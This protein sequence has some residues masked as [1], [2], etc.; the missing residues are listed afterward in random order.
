LTKLQALG[1]SFGLHFA[2]LLLLIFGNLD[3]FEKPVPQ[4][5]IRVNLGKLGIKRDQSLL[6]RIDA[7][8]APSPAYAKASAGKPKPLSKSQKHDP[9]DILKK[10]F[11]KP[12]PSGN[13]NG[14]KYGDS[15]SNELAESYEQQV[16]AILRENYEIPRVITQAEAK[17]LK[18]WVRL[19]IGPAGQL[20]KIK[21]Q[22]PS[23]NTRFDDAVLTGS[24]RIDSFGAPPLTVARRYKSE[25]LLIQFCPLEC[26]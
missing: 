13:P 17:R 21:I 16:A 9:L 3:W 10:R 8:A 26:T 11:G 15:I 12:D 20:I 24:R 22:Q 18:L 4:S 23:K 7:S 19:W 25:G 6:P 1:F 14:S 2:I 5:A